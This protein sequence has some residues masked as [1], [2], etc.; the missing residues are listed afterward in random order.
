[1]TRTDVLPS[2]DRDHYN[3]TAFIE[4]ESFLDRYPQR[5]DELF[6][7]IREGRLCVSPFLCNSLWGFQSVEGALRT[8][9]PARRMEREHGMPIDVAEHIELPSLPWGMASLMAGCGIRWTS[10]PFLDYDSTFKGLNNPSLF[11]LEGPDGSE[12]KVRLDAWAS[13]KAS[14]CEGGYLL[15]D[16]QRVTSE[17]IPHYA[18]LGAAYPRMNWLK[19]DLAFMSNFG[20]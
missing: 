20:L 19:R 11:R 17:W 10:V 18:G 3:A 7:R 12:V 13:L 1:M 9:Y 16:P 8:F 14:Y 2:E 5:Q 4:V 6:R 15:K